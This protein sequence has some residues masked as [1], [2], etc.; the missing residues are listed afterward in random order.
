MVAVCCG[1]L[2]GSLRY[3][4]AAF[5]FTSSCVLRPAMR[6]A[7]NHDAQVL[8]HVR[9]ACRQ[10]FRFAVGRLTPRLLL[11][12]RIIPGYIDHHIRVTR[13]FR[14]APP[15][16]TPYLRAPPT[17]VPY[18]HA[19][20]TTT[21]HTW[22]AAAIAVA[23]PVHHVYPYRRYIFYNR[24]LPLLHFVS[25]I[26]CLFLLPCAH[27]FSCYNLRPVTTQPTVCVTTPHS[28]DFADLQR[29]TFTVYAY[30][31]STAR[32]RRV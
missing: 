23:A 4:V 29:I 21:A 24:I 5:T 6:A 8:R 13:L 1:A 15:R 9:A 10:L 22:F 19:L 17:I 12:T 20:F 25:A 18:L 31:Y 14:A 27:T 28:F 3:M 16:R 2:L 7:T 32:S 11:A 26:S 30:L